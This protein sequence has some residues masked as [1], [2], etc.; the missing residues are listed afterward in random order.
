[1]AAPLRVNL[2]CGKTPTL[3]WTNFD[4]SLSVRLARWPRLVDWLGTLRLLNPEQLQFALDAGASVAWADATKRI[5]LA[6]ESAA[7][8][9]TSHMLEHLDREQAGICLREA[10]RV[11]VHGGVLRVVVPDLGL[12][13]SEYQRDGD[14]DR[15]VERTLLAPNHRPLLLERIR[16]MVIG[17]R[18]HL[19]MYD[20]RSLTRLLMS[21]GFVDVTVQPPGR[22]IIPDPGTLNLFERSDES[23]VVEGKKP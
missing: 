6:N 21:A 16:A 13:T 8:V 7:V 12:L 17:A 18:H 4:N 22:T 1:M 15:L 3:G 20:G 11:L 9:Y 23:V 10:K 5:P 19:W 14:A 2:G